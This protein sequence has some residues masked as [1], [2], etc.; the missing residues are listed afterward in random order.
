MADIRVILADEADE[1]N[2][3]KIDIQDTITFGTGSDIEPITNH[4]ELNQLGYDESGHTGF[5]RSDISVLEES[6]LSN[7]NAL[8]SIY[9]NGKQKRTTLAAILNKVEHPDIPE[10]GTTDH[11]A[12]YNRDKENQHP[13]SAITGLENKF[14]EIEEKFQTIDN[15]FNSINVSFETINNNFTQISSTLN[16]LSESINKNSQD[17]KTNQENIAQTNEKVLEL[18]N[19]LGNISIDKI[20]ASKVVFN[21]AVTTAY[22]IGNIE[23]V[24]GVGTL[25]AK[26]TTLLQGL[27]DIFEKEIIPKITQ[28]SVSITFS[29]AKAYEAG[30]KLTPSYSASFSS[31]SYEFGTLSGT[32]TGVTLNSW[33][34]KD[35]R[36][37]TLTTASGSFSELQVTDGISYKIT[38]TANHSKGLI[39]I[40]SSKNEYS[41]GQIQE[42]S[43]SATSGAITAFRNTFHGTLTTKSD[44][45][46][47][48]V[49]GLAG[50]SGK[51]LSNGNSF[52]VS[53]P[54]GALRVVIA[55]PA[56]LR[57][58]TSI[59][60][61][62]GL[63]AEILS[64]FTQ[65]SN[66][67]V[68]GANDYNAIA[69]KI[70]IQDFANANDKA[71][72]YTVVI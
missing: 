41:S 25:F 17:I 47:T 37:N 34:I 3:I 50:K 60:D 1:K 67:N 24:N 6:D 14:I 12:L 13:I 18:E 9:E 28:P 56:T 66:V 70:Y 52:T 54:V 58:L 55:Y 62:N 69:Y 11:A 31:G 32:G 16:T 65:L 61:V 7:T 51:T 23:L 45:T 57:N 59:K 4:S 36:N 35:T 44:I 63:N 2:S 21:E 33:S 68:Y 20:D 27:K 42:G 40:T 49:R 48:I 10:S 71:N 5:A 43:K 29:Q 53:V 72:T 46:S 19:Q 39:P 64:G 22:K 26:D 8:I 30:T 38:A 15:T